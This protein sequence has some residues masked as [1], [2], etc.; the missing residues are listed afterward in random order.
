MELKKYWLHEKKLPG[1]ID[2]QKTDL[3]FIEVNKTVYSVLQEKKK[4]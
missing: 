1:F 4:N 3:K 2:E